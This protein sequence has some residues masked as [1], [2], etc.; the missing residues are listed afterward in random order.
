MQNTTKKTGN[1]T[2]GTASTYLQLIQTFPPRTIKSELE[3][4]ATQA[5]I[6]KLL[7]QENL[8][9]DERDYLHLLGLLVSEYENNNYSIPDIYGADLLKVLIQERE[10]D[11][12]ELVP[13]F[14]DE[15]TLKQVLENQQIMTQEQMEALADF[16]RVTTDVFLPN[17]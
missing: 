16:F 15:I 1:K 11:I 9:Q 14:G 4:E 12:K 2:L 5:V 3:L 10:L 6:D 13:I 8:T 17:T 7:D